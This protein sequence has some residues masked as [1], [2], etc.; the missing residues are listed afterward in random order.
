MILKGEQKKV[1]FLPVQNPILIKGVAGSGKTT[2]S[3]FRAKHLIDTQNNLFQEAK[4]GIFVFNKT[5]VNYLKLIS[6]KVYSGYLEDSNNINYN[7]IPFSPYIINFHKWAYDF[8]T[9][10]LK[11][12]TIS[13][14]EKNTMIKNILNEFNAEK[15]PIIN[16]N[17][18]FFIEE[19][20][21]IKGKLIDTKE[22]YL[23]TKRIGRGVKDRVLFS[24]KEI[25]WNLFETYNN[26]LK[27]IRKIDFDDYA[28]ICL[29][30]INNDDNWIPPFTHIVIDEAQDLSKAQILVLTKLV[31]KETNSITIVAD[32]AQKIY[33]SG[34]TWS[35]VGLNLVGG[36]TIELRKN[37]RNT[38]EIAKAA[39]SILE[40]DSNIN[41]YSKIESVS[42]E[43]ELTKLYYAENSQNQFVILK[44]II[45]DLK[46]K[47]LLKSTVILH[48]NHIGLKKLE[49]FLNKNS[50][51]FIKLNDSYMSNY[52]SNELSICTMSSIKGLEFENVIMFDLNDNIIPY[53]F[54]DNQDSN[55]IETERRLFYTSMTRAKS[56][57]FLICEKTNPSRFIYEIDENYI[58][59][60]K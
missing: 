6:S 2:I 26:Q 57:L 39:F 24:D 35:E 5:L 40:K 21:W 28:R 50:C 11:I 45:E 44:N 34:F 37:Y 14:K 31:S 53:P 29:D 51:N 60:I 47:K 17:I 54:S 36:R 55:H 7:K 42:R 1:L 4:V 12:N 20:T 8:I 10:D 41:E 3:L 27:E 32:S 9:K 13:E 22:L 16:K 30:K 48:R 56:N 25:I 52:L 33:K 46:V 38:K 15:I 59:I 23:E 49:S 58:T 18:D 43:G 19:F